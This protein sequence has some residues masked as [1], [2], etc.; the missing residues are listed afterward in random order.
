ML[1]LSGAITLIG[2]KQE[3]KK[4]KVYEG[5]K[6]KIEISRL[7]SNKLSA[8]CNGMLSLLNAIYSR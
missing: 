4:I 2:S 7:S 3:L 6:C 1:F 8:M 5:R